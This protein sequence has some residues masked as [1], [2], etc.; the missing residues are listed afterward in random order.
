MNNLAIPQGVDLVHVTFVLAMLV[1]MIGVA[2][3]VITRRWFGA[4]EFDRSAWSSRQ[5]MIDRRCRLVL[6]LLL[7]ASWACVAVALIDHALQPG[8]AASLQT[9]VGPVAVPR[10]LAVAVGLHFDYHGPFWLFWAT[11][12]WLAEMLDRR[13]WTLQPSKLVVPSVTVCF[14][15]CASIFANVAT[16]WG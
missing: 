4:D 1:L 2:V 7:I 8:V 9:E 16:T 12:V 15:A 13:D 14:L 5:I 11:F 3:A 6:C 10:W